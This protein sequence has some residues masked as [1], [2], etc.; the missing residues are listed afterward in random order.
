MEP[1][2]QRG[3]VFFLTNPP[4]Q[5]YRTGDIVVYR[6]PGAHVPIVHRVIETRDLKRRSPDDNDSLREI[7][8]GDMDPDLSYRTRKP[9]SQTA[10]DQLLLTKG[11]NNPTDDTVLYNGLNRLRRGHIIG[12]VRG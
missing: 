7:E 11:D 10:R 4:A 3:D 8:I 6:I 2:F 9:F 1:A 5:Q 12:K